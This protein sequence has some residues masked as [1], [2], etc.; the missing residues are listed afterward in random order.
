[1]WVLPVAHLS[2]CVTAQLGVFP[3]RNEWGPW[4]IV[5]A[6]D[7]PASILAG[8][9]DAVPPILAYGAV[10]TLWWYLLSRA[11]LAFLATSWRQTHGRGP[12]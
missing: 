7:F 5:F 6:V 8:H 11:A 2:L 12:G 4:F 9:L 1:V 10:G 3:P